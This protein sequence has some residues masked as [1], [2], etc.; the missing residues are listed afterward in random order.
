[1]YKLFY[2]KELNKIANTYIKSVFNFFFVNDK[3]SGKIPVEFSI[4]EYWILSANIKLWKRSSI[5][6]RSFTFF[7]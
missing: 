6:G 7:K 4:Y 5:Y 3:K 2:I 1:M